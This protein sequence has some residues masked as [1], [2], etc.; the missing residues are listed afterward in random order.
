MVLTKDNILSVI[1]NNEEFVECPYYARKCRQKVLKSKVEV[2]LSDGNQLTISEGFVWDEASVPYIFQW[3]FPKSGKYA[4][5]AL[6]HDALYYL[7]YKDNQKFCDKELR[8]WME[9]TNIS[10]FQVFFRYL[11][12]RL[13][14]FSYFNRN[15]KNHS[16]RC[17]RNRRFLT[18]THNLVK[19]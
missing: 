8:Y 1:M 13:M 3:A 15:I 7:A 16:Y 2:I 17:I 9:A 18:I 12:V 11:A 6:I 10:K 5:S 4:F 14:G 19:F